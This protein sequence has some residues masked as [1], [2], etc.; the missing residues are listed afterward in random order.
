MAKYRRVALGQHGHAWDALSKLS[1]EPVLVAVRDRVAA[2]YGAGGLLSG[3]AAALALLSG[4][5]VRARLVAIAATALLFAR[6]AVA[7]GRR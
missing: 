5:C 2:V 1:I 7:S 6:R 3:A 4:A